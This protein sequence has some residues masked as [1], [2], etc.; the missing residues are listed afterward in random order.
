[1]HKSIAYNPRTLLNEWWWIVVVRLSTWSL[2]DWDIYF[3]ETSPRPTT[4]GTNADPS[5]ANST[6]LTFIPAQI[7]KLCQVYIKC[8]VYVHYV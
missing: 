1:M 8:N 2:T 4:S 7:A 5:T 6:V 3:N